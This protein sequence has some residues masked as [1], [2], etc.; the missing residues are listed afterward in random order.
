MIFDSV[1]EQ[2]QARR[3]ISILCENKSQELQV[4]IHWFNLS[5]NNFPYISHDLE[6]NEF[7]STIIAVKILTVIC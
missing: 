7:W 5:F 6:F 3:L 1:V 2:T 4:P